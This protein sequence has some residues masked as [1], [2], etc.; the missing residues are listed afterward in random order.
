MYYLEGVQTNVVPQ[1]VTADTLENSKHY[2]AE[3]QTNVPVV[4]QAVNAGPLKEQYALPCRSADKC[5]GS[6]T[7]R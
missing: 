4:S 5:T 3:V 1:A 7:G 6:I 2:L